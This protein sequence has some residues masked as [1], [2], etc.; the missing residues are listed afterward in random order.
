MVLII[1]LIYLNVIHIFISNF[2]F[3]LKSWSQTVTKL[4]LSIFQNSNIENPKSYIKAGP[5]YQFLIQII[6]FLVFVGFNLFLFNIF[7]G[8]IMASYTVLRRK[9]NRSMM[10][11]HQFTQ[12]EDS[13][14]FR[15]LWALL[16]FTY[17]KKK[18]YLEKGPDPA[19]GSESSKL[20]NK[21]DLSSEN[22]F[23][24]NAK[25]KDIFMHNLNELDFVKSKNRK[26]VTKEEL[27]KKLV[28]VKRKLKKDRKIAFG[29][30]RAN[31]DPVFAHIGNPRD[32]H[33]AIEAV[34]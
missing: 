3:E 7:I 12:Q 6:Y 20:V 13:Q 24:H 5:F 16:T 1:L 19:N 28:V 23:V 17:Y 22:T 8:L 11:F 32:G 34:G 21:S 2:D 33:I 26:M 4:S 18:T 10:S 27:V 31:C 15:K 30:S 14:F 25:I 9:Y 29:L